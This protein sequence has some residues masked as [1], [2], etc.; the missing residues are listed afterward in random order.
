MDDVVKSVRKLVRVGKHSNRIGAAEIPRKV[1]VFQ[2]RI[3][4][5]M[6]MVHSYWQIA[7]LLFSLF[8]LFY[9]YHVFMFSGFYDFMILC[10]V[11][12]NYT[13]IVAQKNRAEESPIWKRHP[14]EF[15]AGIFPVFKPYKRT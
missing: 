15:L 11:R 13:Y 14:P 5:R 2:L 12:R 9:F 8:S 3:L 6:L 7:F 1:V 4:P 10:F